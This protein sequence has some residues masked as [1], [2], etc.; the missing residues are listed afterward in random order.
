MTRY[1]A[2]PEALAQSPCFCPHNSTDPDS[3]LP[4]GY[5]DLGPCYPDIS[6]PLA[7]SFPHGI[8]SPPNSLLTHPPRP[9]ASE[10][11]MYFDIN[12]Q[13]GVPLAARVSFQLSA[14]LRPDSSFP[15]LSSISSTRLVPLFWASE[16]FTEPSSWMLSHTRM[17]LALPSA[18][19]LGAA[20]SLLGLGLTCLLLCWW[21][22]EGR[23]QRGEEMMIK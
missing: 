2:H 5:L 16:G 6:P 21:R 18:A 7:V 12:T 8:H 4:S 23:G 11:S 9:Q 19:S 20:G 1:T 22:R 17:A 15:L 3:C 13:L 14:I 10:H